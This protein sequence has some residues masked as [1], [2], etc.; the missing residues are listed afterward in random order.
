MLLDIRS[1]PLH[2]SQVPGRPFV[3]GVAAEG[4]ENHAGLQKTALASVNKVSGAAGCHYCLHSRPRLTS[5]V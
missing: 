2:R 4:G 3:F 1:S 5:T